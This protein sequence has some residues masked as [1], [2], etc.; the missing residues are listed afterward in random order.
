MCASAGVEAVS[1]AG[2]SDRARLEFAFSRCLSRSPRDAEWSLLEEF[3]AKQRAR[4]NGE[5]ADPWSVLADDRAPKP[6]LPAGVSAE[7]MAAW[8]AT[9]RVILNLDETIT[10]E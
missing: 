1:D 10:K 8:T 4:F 9:A 3:L 7:D 2:P 5:G 6:E